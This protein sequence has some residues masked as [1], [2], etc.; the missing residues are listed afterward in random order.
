MAKIGE[1]ETTIY[2]TK[3]KKKLKNEKKVYEYGTIILRDPRLTE[4]IGKKVKVKIETTD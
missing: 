4:H 2:S 3:D 1:F